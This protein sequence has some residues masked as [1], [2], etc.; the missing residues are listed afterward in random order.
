MYFPLYHL[1]Q[2]YLFHLLK[3]SLNKG[4]ASSCCLCPA[5]FLPQCT[6]ILL[7]F[8]FGN[9]IFCSQISDYFLFVLM[10]KI[11]PIYCLEDFPIFDFYTLFFSH[12]LIYF[13]LH[14]KPRLCWILH[15]FNIPYSHLPLRYYISFL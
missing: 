11:K 13:S 14:S 12:I 10:I 15:S 6:V 1:T 9:I 7:L 4:L 3:Q 8:K 2:S 5:A